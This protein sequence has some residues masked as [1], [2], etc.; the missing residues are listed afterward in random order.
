MPQ[1]FS[2]LL[3][4]LHQCYIEH[5]PSLGVYLIYTTFQ[6]LALLLSLGLLVTILTDSFITFKISA[7][8]WD[9][10]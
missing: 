8:A 3:Q 5:Y 9:Q 6:K 1:D 7:K 2:S 4:Q 10:T